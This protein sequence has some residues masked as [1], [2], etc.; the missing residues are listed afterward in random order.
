MSTTSFVLTKVKRQITGVIPI[1]Y[2]LSNQIW[3]P[4]GTNG[5]GGK[6]VQTIFGQSAHSHGFEFNTLK[7]T[8]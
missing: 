8:H 5:P 1:V 4:P 3:H 6:A 7:T 2:L